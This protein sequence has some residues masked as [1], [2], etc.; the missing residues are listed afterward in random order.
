[1]HARVPVS[2]M[3]RPDARPVQHNTLYCFVN[4]EMTII[5]SIAI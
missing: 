5:V 4:D 2:I 3:V 1:M